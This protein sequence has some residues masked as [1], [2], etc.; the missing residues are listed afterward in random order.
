M[1]RQKESNAKD[2]DQRLSLN[3][4]GMVEVAGVEIA[5][6]TLDFQS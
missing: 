4:L 2:K 6:E 1:G 3:D 5:S